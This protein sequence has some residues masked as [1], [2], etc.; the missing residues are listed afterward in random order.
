MAEVA[1]QSGLPD[2]GRNSTM[3]FV[4][5]VYSG[6]LVEKFYK[7][8]VF[9]EIAS[10]DYEGEIAGY[11]SNVKIRTVPD[12]TV[13]AYVIGNGLNA[14]YPSSTA[15]TLSID[16]ANAFAVALNLVD[17]RQSDIDMAD[18]FANEASIRLRIAADVDMLSVI[19]AL[20]SVDNQ[21]R[22]AAAQ[23]HSIDLGD[24]TTPL[25]LTKTNIV[26]Y[27]VDFG[28]VL[29]EQSVP[30]EGRWLVLPPWAIALIKKSDL[31]IAS[32]AG[33]GVSILRN[34]KVGEIDRFTIY[35]SQNLLSQT[36]PGLA[37][38]A[39]FGHSA[40]LTFA[41]QIVECEMVTN[42]NDFG[43]IVRGLMVYGYQVIE[44][45]YVGTAVIRKG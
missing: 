11:G 4:P 22:A 31:R 35:Q 20:V 5:E 16:K 45:K 10:T 21:G 33:D 38:Y 36:T 2:L 3:N 32:L 15:V 29:D 34:G 44:G 42:P 25:S 41:S 23:T 28:T 8:T 7:T 6:K 9:G 40:G 14:V 19:P 26:D 12:I 39:L 1:R 24:S 17:Q 13:S 30:D 43:W 37:N 18:V 27:I